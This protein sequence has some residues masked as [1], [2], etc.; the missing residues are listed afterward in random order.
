MENNLD[1]CLKFVLKWEGGISNH[2]DDA[3]GLTNMGII[4]TVYDAWRIAHNQAKQSVKDITKAE[5]AAIYDERYWTASRAKW[6]QTPLDL[7]V[8]D[9]AVN[10]GVGRANEFVSVALGLSKTS[11][12]IPEMSQKI[13]D[14]NPREIALAICVQRS[15]HRIKR[16]IDVPSQKVFL[17]GWTNRDKALFEAVLC[18]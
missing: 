3:G 11:S 16:V 7:A 14:A 15:L 6:M 4:Q 17:A 9:T 18:I 2:P 10:F 12:W 5:V 8:F 13:H 1:A